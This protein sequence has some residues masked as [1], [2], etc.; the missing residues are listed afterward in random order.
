[1]EIAVCNLHFFIFKDI[2]DVCSENKVSGGPMFI[3]EQ[4]NQQMLMYKPLSI[5]SCVGF[6]KRVVAQGGECRKGVFSE[7]SEYEVDVV[8]FGLDVDKNLKKYRENHAVCKL[9]KDMPV[10]GMCVGTIRVLSEKV[11]DKFDTLYIPKGSL[12]YVTEK[13]IYCCKMY[14]KKKGWVFIENSSNVYGEDAFG[15]LTNEQRYELGKRKRDY[16]G[17]ELECLSLEMWASMASKVEIPKGVLREECSL[18][19]YGV[20]EAVKRYKKLPAYMKKYSELDGCSELDKHRKSL[21]Y[22]LL[23]DTNKLKGKVCLVKDLWE[24]N[25]LL[26][27]VIS[28]DVILQIKCTLGECTECSYKRYKL[29][30]K[31]RCVRYCRF[32]ECDIRVANDAYNRGLVSKIIDKGVVWI[33]YRNPVL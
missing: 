26:G 16:L 29:I 8:W 6:V 5:G 18:E 19:C 25:W 20:E 22:C 9:L 3:L 28:P 14:R 21:A 32:L 23:L 12:I 27:G 13:G 10:A 2:D 30:Q 24:L 7:C 4:L 11:L 33:G 31:L 17:F 15:L 1:M